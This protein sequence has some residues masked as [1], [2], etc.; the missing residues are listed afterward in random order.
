[1]CYSLF[2]RS[3]K[4]PLLPLYLIGSFIKRQYKEVDRE[5]QQN[6]RK[7][8]VADEPVSDGKHHFKEEFERIYE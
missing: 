7:S 6:D 1:M 5:A 2:K 3:L 4:V 8:G